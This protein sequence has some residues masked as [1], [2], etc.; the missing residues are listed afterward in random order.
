MFIAALST[1][2]VG[3][4][5]C[6][7][8][9]V[10]YTCLAPYPSLVPRGVSVATSH[11]AREPP[12]Y[13]PVVAP[14][15]APTMSDFVVCVTPLNYRFDRYLQLTEVRHVTSRHVTSRHVTSRHVTSRHV[16][17]RHVTSRHVTS[18]HATPR[19]VTSQLV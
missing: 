7:Y 18:R 3:V 17:S 14:V 12:N 13:L 15:E 8:E 2:M 9:S 10:M 16:T 11:C 1:L 6:R 5:R 4:V 19:H